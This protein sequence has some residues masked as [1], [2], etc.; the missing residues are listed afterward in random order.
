MTNPETQHQDH[1]PKESDRSTPERADIPGLTDQP[2]ELATVIGDA[3]VEADTTGGELPDWGA[4][5]IARSLADH[6]DGPTPALSRLA[7]TG[8]GTLEAIGDEVRPIYNQPGISPDVKRQIDYL[9]TYLLDRERPTATT[10]GSPTEPLATTEVTLSP[11]ALEGVREHG[12]AFRAFLTLPDTKPDDPGLLDS[13]HEFYVGRFTTMDQ[14]LDSLTEIALWE[15]EIDALAE[16]H[17]IPG[18]ISLD[19]EAIKDHVRNTWDIVAYHGALFVF[20]K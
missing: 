9:L 7:E 12:D 18:Y 15:R 10:P 11:Q 1:G 5:A 8:D 3:L 2:V 14:L 20:D 4:R 13:F 16:R 17:G 6:H 19:L